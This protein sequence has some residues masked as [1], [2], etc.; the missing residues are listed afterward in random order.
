M[1]V[2]VCVCVL[3]MVL[4]MPWDANCVYDRSSPVSLTLVRG[5]RSFALRTRP[6]YPVIADVKHVSRPRNERQFTPFAV[7]SGVL[8]P[9]L[10]SS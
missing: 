6:L 9:A 5:A 3:R 1:C 2:C 4:R 7:D 10:P 8:T